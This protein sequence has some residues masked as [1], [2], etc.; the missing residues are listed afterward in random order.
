[1]DFRLSVSECTSTIFVHMHIEVQVHMHI[2]VQVPGKM[3]N[4]G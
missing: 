3:T 4:K 2:E 1:M